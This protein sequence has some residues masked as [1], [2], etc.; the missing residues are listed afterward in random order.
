V[1]PREERNHTCQAQITGQFGHRRDAQ[2]HVVC[3]HL[4]ISERCAHDL[5]GVVNGRAEEEPDGF[6]TL[7]KRV[8]DVRIREHSEQAES[9]DV[10]HRVGDL[11]FIRVDGGS[12]G[13]DRGDATNAGP[14]GDQR[15]EA[16]RQSQTIVEP[17][18]EYEPGRDGGD[19]DRQ[20]AET[21]TSDIKRAQANA[22]Q[23]DANAQDRRDA[24]FQARDER[25][26]QRQDVSKEQPE[27]DGDR[28][29]RYGTAA[30]GEA[31]SRENGAA[32]DVRKPE[33][34]EHD[35]QRCG[36]TGDQRNHRR[37]RSHRTDP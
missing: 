8:C 25:R 23:H 37:H 36:D 16:R 7:Q 6:G 34:R 19:Y 2:H 1:H 12:R 27:D 3:V 32:Q 31:L 30:G 33:S 28:H 35:Q 10:G 5:R 4:P 13:H 20:A 17:G 22:D 11:A 24:K 26:R 18:D 15:A 14:S 9:H 21:K 29:A